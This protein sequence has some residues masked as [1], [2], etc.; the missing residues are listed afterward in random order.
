[1]SEER[2]DLVVKLQQWIQK[3]KQ[4]IKKLEEDKEFYMKLF[5]EIRR[6]QPTSDD[7]KTSIEIIPE[8]D[9]G[10]YPK[11][12][13]KT[14]LRMKDREPLKG[15]ERGAQKERDSRRKRK[16]NENHY[17]I[18]KNN[19]NT[20]NTINNSGGKEVSKKF[21]GGNTNLSG[22]FFDVSSQDS[23]HQFAD[24]MKAIADYVG[25]EY[26]HGGDVQYM[27]ENLT[28]YQFICPANPMDNQDQIEMESWKKQLDI[29]WKR[30]GVQTTK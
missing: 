18:E 10:E 11:E 9:R 21:S 29:S 1:M 19:K 23:I 14:R 4:D 7:D 16:Q 8:Q 24:T 20:G 28:D 12:T 5:W 26:M 13:R 6:E 17:F 3:I 22:N 27:I 25:Q 30:R 2:E 15:Q